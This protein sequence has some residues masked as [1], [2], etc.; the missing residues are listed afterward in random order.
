MTELR[1]TYDLSEDEYLCLLAAAKDWQYL[2][3]H[4]GDIAR[5]SD[6]EDWLTAHY[7]VDRYTGHM[8]GNRLTETFNPAAPWAEGRP[9]PVLSDYPDLWEK[10]GRT[11]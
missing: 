2:V 1:N 5:K 8:I 9:E 4:N 6:L 7:Q 10:Y 11:K 3:Y